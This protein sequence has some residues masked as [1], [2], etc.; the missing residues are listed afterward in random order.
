M[1][2]GFAAAFLL[3]STCAAGN[4]KSSRQNGII[5]MTFFV[6]KTHKI[7]NRQHRAS[8]THLTFGPKG[9]TLPRLKAPRG[10]LSLYETGSANWIAVVLNCFCGKTQKV[11]LARFTRASRA[12]LGTFLCSN[13]DCD[14]S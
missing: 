7:I 9:A 11:S 10:Y 3:L 14:R 12:T 13:R 4:G 2:D 5:K 8:R 1:C 6:G